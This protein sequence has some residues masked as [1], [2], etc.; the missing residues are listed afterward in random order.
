MAHLKQ[1]TKQH[2]SNQYAELIRIA[3]AIDFGDCLLISN[4]LD[5]L[6]RRFSINWHC[7]HYGAPTV[8]ESAKAPGEVAA[9]TRYRGLQFSS[10]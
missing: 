1:F 4:C 2:T 3:R 9:L 7:P 5:N 10:L 6:I 8:V